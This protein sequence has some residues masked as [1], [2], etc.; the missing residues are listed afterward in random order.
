MKAAEANANSL[1]KHMAGTYHGLRL[2]IGVIG[3]ALPLALWLG[4][5]LLDREAL[6]GSM[7]AYYYSD[8]MRDVFV[9]ALF[10]IGAALYLYKGF[11]TKENVVL[12]FGGLFA[13]GVALVPTFPDNVNDGRLITPH[14]VFAVLFFLC[15]AYVA[16]FRASDTLSLVGDSKVAFRLQATYRSLGIAM[17]VL[18]VAAMVAG[19]LHAPFKSVFLAEALAVWVFGAFWL[20]KSRELRATDAQQLALEGKLQASGEGARS[21]SPGRLVRVEPDRESS[22]GIHGP[23]GVR[24]SRRKDVVTTL[25]ISKTT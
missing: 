7:S 8:A 3:V 12:N 15:I 4:G 5:M 13:V 6:R 16:I 10:M 11:S 24:F 23:A 22:K 17:V 20:V 21:A 18:P 9:G 25:R 2:G 1:S 14:R 19:I